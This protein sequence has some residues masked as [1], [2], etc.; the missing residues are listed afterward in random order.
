MVPSWTCSFTMDWP[1]DRAPQHSPP[2][3]SQGCHA[4][5]AM[6]SQLGPSP[7]DTLHVSLPSGWSSKDIQ[8]PDSCHS[9]YV[10]I[11]LWEFVILGWWSKEEQGDNA[12]IRLVFKFSGFNFLV[13]GVISPEVSPTGSWRK[14]VLCYH[15]QEFEKESF[16]TRGEKIHRWMLL[17]TQSH[18]GGC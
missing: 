17:A 16:F 5:P 6:G 15:A 14:R 1:G 3:P 18:L 4:H 9:P 12:L 10:K 11:T 13:S 2:L 7:L 8:L